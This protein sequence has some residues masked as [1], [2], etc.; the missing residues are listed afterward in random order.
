MIYNHK[1]SLIDSLHSMP[2]K[3]QTIENETIEVA[4][5]EVINPKSEK[6]IP[7]KGMPILNDDPLG[8]IKRNFQRG[9]IILRFDIDFPRT[10]TEQQRLELQ[11]I[12]DEA[13]ENEV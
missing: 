1:I 4:L 6:I 13:D 11:A 9:N 7:G 5:D 10:L 8:P 2:I 12:L 3:F